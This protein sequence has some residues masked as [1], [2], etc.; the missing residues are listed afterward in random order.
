MISCNVQLQLWQLFMGCTLFFFLGLLFSFQKCLHCN[1]SFYQILD[2][3]FYFHWRIHWSF[4]PSPFLLLISLQLTDYFLVGIGYVCLHCMATFY[5]ALNLDG[6]CHFLQ[7]LCHSKRGAG[8]RCYTG[9]GIREWMSWCDVLAELCLLHCF[10]K[11]R[12]MVIGISLF[13][14]QD[15]KT[16]I[17]S[18]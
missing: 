5:L 2:R 10:C 11:A 3:W 18:F 1:N 17:L 4:I 8:W 9:M 14:I 16:K 12:R 6:I 13:E 7:C 15:L